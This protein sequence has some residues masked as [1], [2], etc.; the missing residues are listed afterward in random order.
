MKDDERDNSE[1]FGWNPYSN[2]FYSVSKSKEG[3]Y[4]DFFAD[5]ALA[6]KVVEF[7]QK[8][9]IPPCK[10]RSIHKI[11]RQTFGYDT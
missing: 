7:Y 8:E 4:K 6:K 11:I 10:L 2:I 5:L 1:T 9:E 3:E